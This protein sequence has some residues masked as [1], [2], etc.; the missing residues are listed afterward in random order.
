[1]AKYSV[2]DVNLLELRLSPQGTKKHSTEVVTVETELV[3]YLRKNKK[4]MRKFRGTRSVARSAITSSSAT[5]R[6]N[7]EK[8]MDGG[9]GRG[10]DVGEGKGHL[11]D[12]CV[13]KRMSLNI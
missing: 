6:Q 3:R 13:L 8:W 7:N 12:W 2:S 4:M 11:S 10:I 1:M 5:D 9:I